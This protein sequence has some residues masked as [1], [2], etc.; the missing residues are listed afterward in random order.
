MRVYVIR[1]GESENNLAKKWT[2]WMDAHLTE[3]GKEDARKAGDFLKNISID[4]VF[5]SDLSRAIETAQIALPGCSCEITPLLREINVG[6]LVGKPLS[7]VSE[8]QKERIVKSGYVEFDGETKEHF[9]SRIRQVMDALET[10]NCETVALFSHAGWLRGMLDAVIGMSVP[11][12]YVQCNNCT[13]AIFE[14]GNEIWQ[15]HSWINLS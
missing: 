12:K 13:I 3:K 10:L 14:Y 2:G 11:R 1:H 5:A 9:D 8:A 15:L 4:K 7:I 6:T